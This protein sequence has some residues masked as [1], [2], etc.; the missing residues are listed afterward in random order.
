MSKDIQFDRKWFEKLSI[1][2]RVD[3]LM[4]QEFTCEIEIIDL[5]PVAK[6]YVAGVGL[7]IIG[8]ENE[9]EESMI[10]RAKEWLEGCRK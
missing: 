7:P 9:S 8:I 5:Q 4:G 10:S 1:N 2:E 6:V 3:F